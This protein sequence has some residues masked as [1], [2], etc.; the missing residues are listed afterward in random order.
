MAVGS[1]DS[2]ESLRRRLLVAVVVLVQVAWGA[3]LVFLLVH[4][5]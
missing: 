3:G 2:K 4:F 1:V 5:L